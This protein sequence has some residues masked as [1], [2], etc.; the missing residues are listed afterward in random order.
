[1]ARSGRKG[2]NTFRGS[3]GKQVGSLAS[4]AAA[5]GSSASNDIFIRAAVIESINDLTVFDE[6]LNDILEDSNKATVEEALSEYE[7]P[8][9]SVGIKNIDAIYNVPQNSLIVVEKKGDAPKIVYPFFSSHLSMPVKPGET[10]WV[11]YATSV[12]ENRSEGFWISRVVGKRVSEDVN[13]CHYDRQYEEST[14]DMIASQ[15]TN[16]TMTPGFPHGFDTID[17]R[18]LPEAN[19]FDNVFVESKANSAVA[20][21]PVARFTKRTGDLL[22]QGSNN[23][24]ICLGADRPESVDENSSSASAGDDNLF[25]GTI[26][27]VAGRTMSGHIT[28]NQ[29]G[30]L[31]I[32]KNPKQTKKTSDIPSEGDP[33]FIYDASRLY[34]SSR[35]SGDDNFQLIFPETDGGDTSPVLDAPYAIVKSNEIRLISRQDTENEIAG[36]IKIIKEGDEDSES[37]TGRAVIMLQPNGTI[38]IDGPKIII[39]SGI[40]KSNGS[41]EQIIL[42]RDATEPI[43]LGNELVSIIE[44][45]LSAIKALTVPTGTG[46]SGTP[47]NFAQFDA[48]KN[49]LKNILSKVGKTK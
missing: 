46:P 49:K 26:D 34:V 43:V 30:F 45:L 5:H 44:E 32:D 29:R 39:G 10:V 25:R 13:F 48:V 28:V 27:I 37:G 7:W 19:S 47:I 38:M 14:N 42:G 12:E 24:L 4:E 36:S 35:T 40:E 20:F 11:T 23:T 31:E 21:E 8:C 17:T 33:N 1:M 16:D 9:G 3:L 22:L 41:G 15:A 18:M 6:F 2:L